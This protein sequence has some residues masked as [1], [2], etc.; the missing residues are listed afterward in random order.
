MSYKHRMKSVGSAAPN[1]LYFFLPNVSIKSRVVKSCVQTLELR[2]SSILHDKLNKF[3]KTW[4]MLKQKML[5]FCLYF[6]EPISRFYTC[7]SQFSLFYNI[8]NAYSNMDIIR[9]TVY[10]NIFS[11]PSLVLGPY[12]SRPIWLIALYFAVY[13]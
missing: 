5:A 9:Y 2:D 4:K 7:P 10:C 12:Y 11:L 3:C 6:H 8:Y 1:S 13:D